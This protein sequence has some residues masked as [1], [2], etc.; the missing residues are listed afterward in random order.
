[1][2]KQIQKCVCYDQNNALKWLGMSKSR[3]AAMAS[4]PLFL[5]YCRFDSF[6][7]L[8]QSFCGKFQIVCGVWTPETPA[9]RMYDGT[10]FVLLLCQYLELCYHNFPIFGTM[11]HVFVYV[12]KFRKAPIVIHLAT[13]SRVR[14][15][16]VPIFLLIGHIWLL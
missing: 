16:L 12:Y 1:M 4:S 8:R 6:C 10:I 7:V 15:M 13:F 14:A 3:M 5:I 11:R 9:F 2:P